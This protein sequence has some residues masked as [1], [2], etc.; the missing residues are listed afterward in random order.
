MRKAAAFCIIAFTAMLSLTGCGDREER[1]TVSLRN[2]DLDPN[3]HILYFKLDVT[4]AKVASLRHLPAGWGITVVNEGNGNATA[5]GQA[6][7]GTAALQSEDFQKFIVL[8]KSGAPNM[9]FRI[10]GELELMWFGVPERAP[11]SI[12][13]RP[14]QIELHRGP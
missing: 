2:L 7:V 6:E 14:D 12:R 1:Y 11:R 3:D 8:V 5:S 9:R 10:S 13:L 4:D